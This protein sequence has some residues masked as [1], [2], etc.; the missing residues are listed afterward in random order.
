MV[1]GAGARRGREFSLCL[2]RETPYPS[3]RQAHA[4][5]QASGARW[6]RAGTGRQNQCNIIYYVAR[7]V[8]WGA[9]VLQQIFFDRRVRANERPRLGSDG[10]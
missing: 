7:F 6:E 4:K 9:F 3:D 10:C 5:P 1:T 8:K 2:H